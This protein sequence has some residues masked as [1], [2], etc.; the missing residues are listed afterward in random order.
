MGVRE[1]DCTAALEVPGAS[2]LLLFAADGTVRRLDRNRLESTWIAP[3]DWSTRPDWF[4]RPVDPITAISLVKELGAIASSKFVQVG[5]AMRV[6]RSEVDPVPL[7]RGAEA[8]PT[9]LGVRLA[10]E[11]A[12]Q[13]CGLWRA[14]S[15]D[16]SLVLTREFGR[17][18]IL[19]AQTGREV[20]RIT[21]ATTDW[22]PGFTAVLGLRRTSLLVGDSL[23]RVGLMPDVH[24]SAVKTVSGSRVDLRWVDFTPDE[25]QIAMG[26]GSGGVRVV[27]PNGAVVFERDAFS[28]S[29]PP[30]RRLGLD[31]I[32]AGAFSPDGSRLVLLGAGGETWIHAVDTTWTEVFADTTARASPTAY[33]FQ[34]DGSRI[35]IGYA[36]GTLRVLAT[37]DGAEIRTLRPHFVAIAAVAFSVDGSQLGSGSLDGT[38][39]VFTMSTGEQTHEYPHDG[40]PFLL[41]FGADGK[42]LVTQSPGHW[43]FWPLNLRELATELKPRELTDEEL[44]EFD[45]PTG[46]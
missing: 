33:A 30:F 9:G 24:Q 35:A 27:D 7:V 12:E 40:V 15:C 46:K 38:A 11:R 5:T 39:K 18:R 28:T 14:F 13:R 22:G 1:L 23:G 19:D 31:G 16:R 21:D 36:D 29:L 2:S 4:Y 25:Q 26:T 45:I 34:E 10:H 6:D 43:H 3:S 41:G 8:W 37:T 44:A 32:T 17:T 20:R 42:T